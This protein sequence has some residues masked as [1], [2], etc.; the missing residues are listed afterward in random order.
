MGVAAPWHDEDVSPFESATAL[1]G[2]DSER[3]VLDDALESVRGG[4]P[5]TVVIG[6]EA[7][8]GKS[9][10]LREFLASHTHDAHALL[11]QC[12]DLGDVAAAYTP[13]IPALRPLLARLGTPRVRELTGAGARALLA[14]FPELDAA[15]APAALGPVEQFHEAVA[16]VLEAAS[17]D[18]PV[19]LVFEDVHWID[20]ASLG[21]LRF[22]TRVLTTGRIL[23]VF[24]YRSDDVGRGHPVRRLLGELE[25]DRDVI[26][27]MLERLLHEQV[28]DLALEL[29]GAPLPEAELEGLMSRSE[30]V[31]F[32]VEELVAFGDDDPQ[33]VPE[34]LRELLLARYERLHDPAQRLARVLAV[35]GTEVE[36]VLLSRVWDGDDLD[37]RAR[38]ALLGGVIQ[39]DHDAYRFRHA[40]VREAILDDVLPGEHERIHARYAAEYERLADETKR[41]L[42][43]AIAHHW[44]QARDQVR[45]FPATLRAAREARAALAFGSAAQH[46][47]RALALWHAVPDAERVAGMSKLALSGRTT[48]HLRNAGELER[49]LALVTAALEECEPGTLDEALL[50]HNRAKALAQL[51]REETLDV[52]RQSLAAAERLDDGSDPRLAA[53]HS[54]VMV[55]FSGRLMLAGAVS[56]ARELALSGAALARS[57][58]DERT[59]SVGVNVAAV[60]LVATGDAVG[61]LREL[62]DAKRIAADDG[63]AQVRYFVNASDAAHLLGQYQHAVS[64]AQ[65]GVDAARR[66]GFERTSGVL[67]SSNLAEPLVWLGEW[68]RADAIITRALSLEPPRSYRT[69]LLVTKAAMLTWR[70]NAEAAD[71]LLR[72]QRT[73]L[74]ASMA[75]EVQSLMGVGRAA[76]ETALAMGDVQAAWEHAAGLLDT[77]PARLCAGRVHACAWPAARTIAAARASGSPRAAA[78]AE[79]RLRALVARFSE[80]PIHDVWAPVIDAELTNTT[81]AWRGALTAARD[82]RAP[83][84]LE[85]YVLVRLGE[86]LITGGERS[87]ARDT[88]TEAIDAAERGGVTAMRERALELAADAGLSSAGPPRRGS[89]AL[90]ERE[91]QVLALVAEG[92]SNGQIGQRLFISGKTASVHVSSILRKLGATS[93]TE[94]AH[95]ASRDHETR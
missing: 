31:P 55:S 73:V 4:T 27:I 6:G 56:E 48:T 25:R 5:R 26:R 71:A 57:H 17:T 10:L 68:S 63:P 18:E 23:L 65:Q 61:A 89:G 51:A 15:D 80:W 1:I 43:A 8:I 86:S 76:T 14:L 82:E 7:G 28:R 30:G 93:R 2:R 20:P 29:R 90:T 3:R 21:L 87:A 35:G 64:L 85:P 37:E 45:A 91:Q 47:E 9:R 19:I 36:H 95:L 62:E 46:G 81:D 69:H 94:A 13:V 52:F 92:L 34:T 67:L 39:A 38:E 58:G 42:S 32:F 59:A 24:S 77:D 50:L 53:L 74:V 41:P 78:D 22:L 79:P 33:I 12:V 83:V 72:E 11:G 66:L 70:G 44:I 88:L 84:H 75:A 60:C 54:S 16:T 49:S 40:L